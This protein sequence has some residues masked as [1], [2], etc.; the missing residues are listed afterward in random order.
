MLQR[1]FIKKNSNFVNEF[2]STMNLPENSAGKV[3]ITDVREII[4]IKGN[5]SEKTLA[6]IE[7]MIVFP[8]FLI[9]SL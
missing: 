5:I 7:K 3:C 6:A 2:L 8:Y 9:G 1:F 4:E